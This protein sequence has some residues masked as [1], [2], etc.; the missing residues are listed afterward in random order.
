MGTVFSIDVRDP[1]VDPAEIEDVVRWLH[2]VDAT[3]S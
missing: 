1:V 2:W 3:F